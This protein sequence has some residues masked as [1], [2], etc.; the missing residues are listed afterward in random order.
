MLHA[1]VRAL[2]LAITAACFLTVSPAR[3]DEPA[4][5]AATT[6]A[7]ETAPKAAA[8]KEATPKAAP[9]KEAAV[10]EAAPKTAD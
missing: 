9:A 8:A 1:P 6:P 10:K 5:A 4:G 3:A 2:G 7:K